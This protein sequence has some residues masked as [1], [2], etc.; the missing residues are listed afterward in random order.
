MR[1]LLIICALAIG[2]SPAAAG[3]RTRTDRLMAPLRIVFLDGDERAPVRQAFSGDASIDV[4]RVTGTSTKCTPRSCV[5]QRR[6]RLRVDGRSTARFVTVRAF[7][8]VEM[9]GQRVR[10]DGR[11]LSTAP[12]LVDASA[13]LGI[14]TTHTLEI[15]VFASEPDG[16]L[17]HT[18]QWTVEDLP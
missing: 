3:P 10:V 11:L 18:I 15:E 13:P 8:G 16:L 6:F 7:L 4:G 9:S 5:I 1:S 2:A 12:T 14:A 17:A